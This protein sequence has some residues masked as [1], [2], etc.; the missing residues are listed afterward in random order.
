MQEKVGNVVLEVEGMYLAEGV[1]GVIVQGR[2][3]RLMRERSEKRKWAL[4]QAVL[5]QR[6]TLK[7]VVGGCER[8]LCE[9]LLKNKKSEEICKEEGGL[10]RGTKEFVSVT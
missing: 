2:V 4:P 5:Y 3:E 1:E 10:R 7:S 9:E 8:Y 6:V